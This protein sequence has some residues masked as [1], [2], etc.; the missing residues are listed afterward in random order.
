MLA[1]VFGTG[2]MKFD[3]VKLETVSEVGGEAEVKILDLTVSALGQSVK[4]SE[5]GMSV[6]GT[7]KLKEVNGEWLF[8]ESKPVTPFDTPA[9]PTISPSTGG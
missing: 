2:T 4:M 3:D 6:A 1:T 5:L 9:V 7:M 8:S